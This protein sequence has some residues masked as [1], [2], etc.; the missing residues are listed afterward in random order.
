VAAAGDRDPEAP[1]AP[2]H[3]RPAVA[4]FDAILEPDEAENLSAFELAVAFLARVSPANRLRRMDEEPAAESRRPG[5]RIAP[6][7]PRMTRSAFGCRNEIAGKPECFFFSARGI[8]K[9]VLSR[10][11]D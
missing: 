10:R 9:K 8:S 4:G 7:S 2:P 5:T 6:F 1:R 3:V 11:V